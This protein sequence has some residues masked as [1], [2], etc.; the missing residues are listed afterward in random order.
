MLAIWR[1]GGGGY[2]GGGAGAAIG[3]Q[4]F[5]RGRRL[6]LPQ[7]AQPACGR[8]QRHGHGRRPERQRPDHR[9]LR[10]PDRRHLRLGERG[11]DGQGRPRP[12]AHG[13]RG[14]AARL[15]GLPLARPLLEA[16]HPLADRRQGIGG[17]GLVPLPRPDGEAGSRLPLPDQGG[18]PRRHDELVRAGARDVGRPRHLPRGRP[19]GAKVWLRRSELDACMEAHRG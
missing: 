14:R 2:F 11:Q 19:P 8:Q 15:P 17:R 5:G 13:H 12:L 1:A 4:R 6:R 7:S 3:G 10:D 9:H 16:A 18:Q